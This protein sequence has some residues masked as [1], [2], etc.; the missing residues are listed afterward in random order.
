MLLGNILLRHYLEKVKGEVVGTI[1]TDAKVRTYEQRYAFKSD[2]D[3]IV[4]Q[5]ADGY[6]DQVRMPGSIPLDSALVSFFGLYSGDGAKGTEVAGVMQTAISFSQIE[7]NLIRFAIEQFRRLFGGNLRFTFSLG[8]D[9]AFFMA[10]EGEGLLRQF[11]GGNIPALKTLKE[12]RPNLSDK[13]VQYLGEERRQVGTNEEHLAFYYQHKDA[14]QSILSQVKL[15]ELEGVG[16][17]FGAEDKVTASLRRPFKKG[18]R[19]PGGTSRADEIHIGGLNGFGTLFLKILYELEDSI[20]EGTKDSPQELIQWLEK[21]SDIGEVVDVTEFF[22]SSPF[23][24]IAGAR[25]TLRN[26]GAGLVGLWPRS[27]ETKI[28]ES[29][30]ITPLFSYVSGLYLAEGGT[31]KEEL[32]AMYIRKPDGLSVSFTSSEERSITL[33]L[34]TMVSLFEPGDCLRSWKIKVGS[35]YFP[36]LVVIG[37]KHGVPMLRGGA[38]GDGKLR[39]ME[40]SLA[41]KKWALEVCPSLEQYADKYSHV[42]PTGAG[43]AR[44]DFSASPTLGRWLFPLMMYAVFG[45]N[46]DDPKE[47]FNA[48]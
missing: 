47:Q 15:T 20:Y 24:E 48:E 28:S 22:T 35:Q 6:G 16:I 45:E 8:E 38:S 39:T 31:P 29:V 19:L 7:P 44:M 4:I 13:D 12:V 25:P 41:L 30:R 32:F 11:Y 17:E 33:M 18:A 14:M 46:I 10:G 36:E 9:A 40:I 2:G 3:E 23:G 1:R 34:R 27:R 42:E 5:R 21:P 26:E 43:L 37:L